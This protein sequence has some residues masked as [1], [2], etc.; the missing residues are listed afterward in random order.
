MCNASPL[1]QRRSFW[2]APLGW[3]SQEKSA[4]SSNLP[5]LPHQS[6]VPQMEESVPIHLAVGHGTRISCLTWLGLAVRG[7]MVDWSGPTTNWT[8]VPCPPLRLTA[9]NPSHQAP[10]FPPSSP[11]SLLN[12]RGSLLRCLRGG[13]ECQTRPFENDRGWTPLI[14]GNGS[15]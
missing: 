13:G 4:S 9:I 3:L 11:S 8:P 5:S 1:G 12:A 15:K 7:Q 2:K 14:F 10:T 6:M